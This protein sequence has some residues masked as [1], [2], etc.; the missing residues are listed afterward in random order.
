VYYDDRGQY[1]RKLSAPTAMITGMGTAWTATG[2]DIATMATGASALTAAF[3][4]VRG[5]WQQQTARRAAIRNRNWHAYVM[6]EGI[7]DWFV[8]LAEEP[9]SPTARVV[10]EVV[11]GSGDPDDMMAHNMRQIITGDGRL[12]RAPTE[13]EWSFLI[14]Q[15][16]ERGY[17]KGY[18]V[19]YG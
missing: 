14:A 8:R 7:N 15:R 18:P 17:G 13:E 10:L 12:A 4:W 1:A 2:A 19:R 5:Q 6:P 3:V 11:N 9:D 16:K